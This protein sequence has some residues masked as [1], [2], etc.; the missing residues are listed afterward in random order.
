M[1]K[2]IDWVENDRR[3]TVELLCCTCTA[4]YS[5]NRL[6]K[7]DLFGQPYTQHYCTLHCKEVDPNAEP[8][9]AFK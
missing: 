2:I 6:E 8:C 3:V 1:D 7:T 4:C 9:Q 5:Y